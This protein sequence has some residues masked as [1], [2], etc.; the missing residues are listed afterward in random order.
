MTQKKAACLHPAIPDAVLLGT[1]R[2]RLF[3]LLYEHHDVLAAKWKG[4]R[5]SWD[6]VCEWATAEE[7]WDKGGKPPKAGAAR[8]TWERVRAFKAL[9][10]AETACAD[11]P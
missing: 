4:S 10:R 7:A 6:A 9:E 8:K 3:W 11:A 1:V 2:S 5:V